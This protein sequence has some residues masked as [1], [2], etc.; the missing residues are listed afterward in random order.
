MKCLNSSYKTACL[1][2]SFTDKEVAEFIQFKKRNVDHLPKKYAVKMV[3][4]QSDGSWVM[5][6]NVHLSSEGEV[7]DPLSSDFVWIGHVFSGPGV[8]ASTQECKIELPLTTD[9]LCNLLETLRV[10]MAHNFLPSVMTMAAT[11]LALHYQTMQQKLS[12]VPCH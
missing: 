6:S 7:I 9:P 10:Q 3:G 5:A 8:A 2:C 12:S 11:I 4:Q 1:Q